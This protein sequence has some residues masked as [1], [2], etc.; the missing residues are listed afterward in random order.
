MD[1]DPAPDPAL[2]VS[3]FQD[4]AQKFFCLWLFEGTFTLFFKDKKSERSHKAVEIKV[5][6]YYFCFLIEG[7]GSGTLLG[8]IPALHEISDESYKGNSV[9]E[10]F[11]REVKYEKYNSDAT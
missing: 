1:L 4:A 7:S 2:F 11:V 9:R 3:D 6:F 5:F 8:G 10:Q